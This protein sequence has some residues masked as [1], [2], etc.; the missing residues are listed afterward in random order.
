MQMRRSSTDVFHKEPFV[1]AP[2]KK[3]CAEAVS[4]KRTAKHDDTLRFFLSF[5]G[6]NTKPRRS[7]D[8]QR[9]HRSLFFGALAR[10]T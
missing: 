5:K 6:I 4:N 3:T 2:G 7:R 10:D 1:D 8:D 9:Q